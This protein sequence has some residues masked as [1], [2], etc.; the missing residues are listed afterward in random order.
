MSLFVQDVPW[1]IPTVQ[2]VHILS[3]AVVIS[4]AMIVEFRLLRGPTQRGSLSVTAARFFPWIWS[5]VGVLATSGAIL[6][7]G[8]PARDLPNPVFQIKMALVTFVIVN[9][10]ILQRKIKQRAATGEQAIAGLSSKV[11]G[12]ISLLAWIAIIFAGR[13]IAYFNASQ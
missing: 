12:L 1:V 9:T 5:A 2:I 6:I 8:E 7:S 11:I 10:M 3:I 4:S 13:W